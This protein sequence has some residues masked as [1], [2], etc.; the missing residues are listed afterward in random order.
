MNRG[1]RSEGGVLETILAGSGIFIATY[2]LAA[3]SVALLV[4]RR[5]WSLNGF[6]LSIL[7]SAALFG[8]IA[9]SA[10]AGIFA[11]RFG[12]RA[13]LVGDFIAYVAASVGSAFSPDFSWLFAFRFIV[14]IGIGADFAVVFPY[15]SEI[16]TAGTRG[17]N[18]ATVMMAANFGMI[19]AYGLGGVFLGAGSQGWRIVLL[20]GGLMAVPVIFM[21]SR[22]SESASWKRSRLPHM[23]DILAG[24]RRDDIKKIA[25]S[26]AAWFSYQVSDQGLSVFLPLLLLTTLGT[27]NSIS[28]YGSLLVKSVTIPAAIVTVILIDRIGRKPLQ[29]SG[30]LGR[31]VPL[32]ALSAIM[33]YTGGK[34]GFLEI[35]LL[36]AAYFFGAMG[37]DK[38]IVISP[39]EQFGTEIRATGQG[40]AESIGRTGGLAGV[41]GYGILSAIYG[42]WA[43][44]MYFG[45]FAVAGFLVSTIMKE[46]GP[47]A[48]RDRTLAED[49]SWSGK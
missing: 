15:I 6:E 34:Y 48:T 11:D 35:G 29:I 38:T 30:F 20:A 37:P 44:I 17:R 36:L 45:I 28:S 1:R 26:S 13:L 25:V 14:G 32:I 42:P 43:G 2:D 39:A 3:I 23:R 12:R 8:A 24:F 19:I 41:L 27:D 46:T 21:R 9:G 31:A 5:A 47:M 10:T 4:L 16:K 18:M 49:T 40:I 33:V 7:G 22:I